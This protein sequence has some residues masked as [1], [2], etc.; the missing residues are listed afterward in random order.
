MDEPQAPAGWYV[1]PSGQRR[2]WNGTEW[3]E[4]EQE[5][6]ESAGPAAT[7]LPI[8]PPQEATQPDAAREVERLHDRASEWTAYALLLTPLAIVGIIKNVQA[9]NLG[10]R[11]GIDVG[12]GPTYVATAILTIATL[13]AVSLLAGVI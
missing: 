1:M 9:H 3:G 12:W 7:A 10:K 5:V 11:H 6:W 13:V 4:T 2:Y 8:T